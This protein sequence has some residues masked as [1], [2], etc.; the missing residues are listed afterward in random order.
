MDH[1]SSETTLGQRFARMKTLNKTDLEC[2]VLGWH[3]WHDRF[4]G[5]DVNAS[6]QIRIEVKRS[7]H[8]PSVYDI[9]NQIL[10]K[11]RLTG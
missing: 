10:W 1:I 2:P 3:G 7:M 8:R 4:F 5:I 9:R 11:N 6:R